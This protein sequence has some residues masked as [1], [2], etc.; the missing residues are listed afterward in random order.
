M[1]ITFSPL[2]SLRFVRNDSQIGL[3]Y[4]TN[5]YDDVVFYEQKL[6]WQGK[7]CFLQPIQKSDTLALMFEV[8]GYIISGGG[9][10]AKLELK[11]ANNEVVKSINLSNTFDQ[12]SNLEYFYISPNAFYSTVDEGNYYFQLS[13]PYTVSGSY[14]YHIYYSEPISLKTKHQDS[15]LLHYTN[16]YN[17]YSIP[18]ETTN[19]F[20]LAIKN[21][22]EY[23]VYGA[24]INMQQGSERFVFNDQ[25]SNAVSLKTNVYRT[26]DFAIGGNNHSLPDWVLEKVNHIFG[27]NTIT[28]DNVRYSPNEGAVLEK[29][30]NIMLNKY[31]ASISVRQY[32][33]QDSFSQESPAIISLFTFPPHE[34]AYFYKIALK[35]ANDVEIFNMVGHYITINSTQRDALITKLNS[36]LV[37]QGHDGAFSVSANELIYTG[38]IDSAARTGEVKSLVSCIAV[39]FEI[40]ALNPN[41]G[42]GISFQIGYSGG[43]VYASLPYI[44]SSNNPVSNPSLITTGNYSLPLSVGNGTHRV[45]IFFDGLITGIGELYGYN[46]K[47]LDL[48]KTGNT[49]YFSGISLHDI[50]NA[51]QLNPALLGDVA[52]AIYSIYIDTASSWHNFIT[53]DN[54]VYGELPYSNL[55]SIILIESAIVGADIDYILNDMYNYAT[56]FKA[57]YGYDPFSQNILLDFR[58]NSGA[59]PTAASALAQNYIINILNGSII[60]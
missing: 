14:Y 6:S 43:T 46:L 47:Q 7:A 16:S 60:T 59:V 53:F 36:E 56:A 55:T 23:R 20:L 2:N 32:N 48:R 22:L 26:W 42:N 30:G 4:N 50:S 37:A 13:V 31:Y 33:Y 3:R 17:Q 8:N 5:K 11:N 58:F 24:L 51:F 54:M 15:V 19:T 25:N 35:N 38:T 10:Q 34:Y 41:S 49:P 40:S 39:D 18:F 12:D 1:K 44:V 27:C 57:L 29:A 52:K 9:L 21:N 28:I 45:L